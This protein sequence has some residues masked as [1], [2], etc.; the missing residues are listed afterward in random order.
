L[1]VVSREEAIRRR[2]AWQEAGEAVVLTNGCFD[3]LHVGHL[4]YLEA[5]RSF[6]RLVVAVNSDRSVREWKGPERPIVPAA[7]RAELVAA[8][9]CVDLVTIFDESTGEALLRALRPEVYVKGADYGPGG[10]DLPEAVVAA[11]VGARVEL[12]PLVAGH[13]TSDL[14]DAIRR[15]G[16]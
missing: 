1:G 2:A 5:A 6:G 16:P 7:E 3:L 9:R 13:S 14:I 12:V 11:E 10:K 8:L 4:R 15:G